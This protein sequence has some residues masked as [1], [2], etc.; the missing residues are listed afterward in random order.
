MRCGRH[1]ARWR[2]PL[3]LLA[4]AWVMSAMM[5]AQS[6]VPMLAGG[7]TSSLALL[8]NGT[9]KVWGDNA[10][11][12]LGLGLPSPGLVT[13]PQQIP[14][15]SLNSVLA[16]STGGPSFSLALLTNGTV[17]AWGENAFGQLGL[18]NTTNQTTPQLIPASSLGN[19]VAVA[20]GHSHALALLSNGTVKAWGKNTSGQLGLGGIINQST[21][22][23]IPVASLS[24]VAAIAAGYGHSLALLSNGTV[25]AWGWNQDRQLGLGNNTDQLTP[26]QIPVGSLS[27]AVAIAAAAVH[28]LALHANGRVSS[29]GNNLAGQLGFGTTTS[30]PTPQQIPASSLSNVVAIQGGMAHSFALLSNG[31]VKAWGDDMN[32]QLGLGGTPFP[33]FRPTPQQIPASSL[34]NVRAIVAGTWHTLALMTDGT[35]KAWGWNGSGTLGLAHLTAH[36]TP[37]LIP[38]LCLAD[39]PSYTMQFGPFGNAA[40]GMTIPC[41]T[42]S[43]AFGVQHYYFNTFS[44]DALNATNPGTGSWQG[45]HTTPAEVLNWLDWG[46]N[47]LALALGPLGLTGG[48]AASVA[49]APA[50]LSGLAVYGVSVAFHPITLALVASSPV[51]SHTF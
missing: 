19:V 41:N 25:K 30:Q 49:I 24:G 34:C 23:Q 48:A 37:Q 21:P 46:V 5:V 18:G 17:M 1:D 36:P 7:F 2:Y 42:V 51:T 26:Q 40:L 22:Q 35:V 11:G 9:V 6:T 20:A 47:G 14:A 29:W 39:A 13:A 32:G 33:G 27:N 45:L 8:P 31:T 10:L 44:A 38:G 4:V 15:S 16:I 28:S 12:Q 43:L 3:L 50:S